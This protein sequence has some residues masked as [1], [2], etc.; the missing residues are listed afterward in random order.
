[1]T[2]PPQWRRLA[3]HAAAVTLGA[4]DD[5]QAPPGRTQSPASRLVVTSQQE[6]RDVSIEELIDLEQQADFFVVLGQD[7]SAID[8]LMAHLRSTGGGSPLPYLKLL[9][10][11]RRRGDREAYER[12]RERFNHRFNAYAPDW[13]ADPQHGRSLEDYPGVVRAPAA[14]LADARST[15][16]PSSRRCCSAAAA[17]SCSTCRPTAKCCS[18]TRWRATC[19]TDQAGRRPT[20]TCC[21][22]S[23]EPDVRA[24]HGGRTVTSAT[25]LAD[26]VAPRPPIERC[27]LEPRTSTTASASHGAVDL[28]P[29]KPLPIDD[30]VDVPPRRQPRAAR[31]D[32]RS[33]SPSAAA[34][35]RELRARYSRARRS[36]AMRSVSSRLAKHSARAAARSRRRRTPTA[37]S[38]PRRSR[39]V[40]QRQN[41]SS[42]QVADGAVV[43]ALEV[44]ALAGQQ[45]AAACC[46]RPARNR[47]RLRW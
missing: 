7:E 4:V 10:I 27:A 29:T 18:C 20:S 40:S 24:R 22:R 45:L 3:A 12:T 6:A 47:S 37:G 35:E 44:A 13:E 25:G 21:C 2:L 32:Q 43:D 34:A 28:D 15:R 19:S 30:T 41:S 9:E 5:D 23:T 38:P 33:D 36:S 1:M 11:Y 31:P 16:W 46:A 8:L 39:V 42:L 14:R 17:A 26:R